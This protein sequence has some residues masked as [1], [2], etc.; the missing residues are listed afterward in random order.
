MAAEGAK[1]MI[2]VAGE[3]PFL[4]YLLSSLAD[5]GVEEIAV[6]IG[7]RHDFVRRRYTEVAIPKRFRLSFATQAEPRGTADAVRSAAAFVDGHDFLVVNGDN[8]YPVAALRAL[9]V[10]ERTGST[11]IGYQRDALVRESNIDPARIAWFALVW[12]DRR[13]RLT[14]IV[15]KPDPTQWDENALIS[16]NSWRF[17]PRILEACS[18]ITPSARG[19]LELQDAVRYAMDRL[20]EPFTVIPWRGGVLDLSDQ[21]D[22]ATVTAWLEGIEVAL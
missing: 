22:I 14:R 9:A 16:M 11:L 7:P 19:E 15:E 12:A 21:A 17:S 3:R 20:G 1:A 6:V 18:A 8:L 5:A 10:P 4:D 2:T 13:G